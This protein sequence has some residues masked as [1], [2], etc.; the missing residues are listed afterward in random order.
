MDVH[1]VACLIFLHCDV[2]V[3]LGSQPHMRE[4]VFG[5]E[6]RCRE[7]V[8]AIGHKDLHVWVAVKGDPECIAR[9]S[10]LVLGA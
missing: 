8:V 6:E 2:L 1:H 3:V 10:E 7:I 9:V 5:G 4:G